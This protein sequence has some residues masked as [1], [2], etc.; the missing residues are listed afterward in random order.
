MFVALAVVGACK[1]TTAVDKTQTPPS[2]SAPATTAEQD[3]LWALAPEGALG[4]MI[5]T[6]AALAK[7]ERGMVSIDK[8]FATAPDLAPFKAK[9]EEAFQDVLG[10]KT[11]TLAAAGLTAKQGF[12]AF[13]VEQEAILIVP[14]GDRDKFVSLLKGTKG[15]DGVDTFKKATCK[16]VKNVYACAKDVALLDR[17]GKGSLSEK[18]KLVGARGDI[19]LAFTSPVEPKVTAAAVVQIGAGAFTVRAAAKDLPQMATRFFANAKPRVDGDKTAGFAVVAFASKVFAELKDKVPPEPLFGGVTADVLVKSLEGPFTMTV[20]NGA[21]MFD[22]RMPLNDGAPAE[23]LFAQCDQFPPLV[24]MGATVKD[25]I[26]HV[27][28]P[29]MQFELDGWVDGKTLRIGKKGAPAATTSSPLSPIG[30]ELADGEWTYAMFGRG[31]MFAPVAMTLPAPPDSLPAEAMLGIRAL[32]MLNELGIGLRS[33]GDVVRAVV[34]VRTLWANPDDVVAK[35]VAI[36]PKA[37]MAGKAG[38]QGKAIADGA[39]SSPFAADYKTGMAGLMMPVATIGMLSAVAIPAFMDY[40]KKSK[41]SEAALQL[42]KLGKNLKTV[43]ITESAFPKGKVGPSPSK[44]CCGSDP[45]NKCQPDPATWADPVWKALDF[46]INEPH[47]YRYSYESTDGTSFVATAAGD[48]D[49]DGQ[50]AVW[51]LKGTVDNGNPVTEITQPPA[52]EY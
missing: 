25:G 10:T 18:L 15:A 34:T 2:P 48:L 23:K 33:D 1:K 31:T 22:V 46:E 39:P 21:M 41:K 14:V 17:L 28:V 5:V 12:A 26:C 27:A 42:N 35:L 9:M 40:M 3:A 4:G 49:C 44:P 47:M 29:Q 52:G 24:R 51:T 8:L 19:E 16:T 20:D 11:L 45:S 13:V 43:Y 32:S 37:I 6:P 30:K 36:D 38:E 50:E 7:I